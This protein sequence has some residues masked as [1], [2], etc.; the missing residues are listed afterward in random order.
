[1]NETRQS[2]VRERLIRLLKQ[3]FVYTIG[4]LA[5]PI[6]G[7][8]MVPIYTRVF[9]PEDYGIIDLIQITIV[10]ISV[11]LIMGTDNATGRFYLDK[12]NEKDKRTIAA[13]SLIFR[14]VVLA[15]ASILLVLFSENI[16]QMLFKSGRGTQFLVLAIIAIPFDHCFTLCLNMLRY[17]YRSISYTLLSVGKLIGKISLI[18]LFVVF[19]KWGIRGVFSAALISSVVFLIAVMIVTRKYFSFTFSV[20]RLKE[21]LRYGLP[22]VPYGFTVYL[23][24]NCARYFL[25]H[26]GTLEDVGLYAV[27]AKLATLISFVFIGIGAALDPYIFSSYKDEETRRLYL[28]TTNYLVGA[29]VV[30]VLGL[31]LFTREILLIF[32]T[33][34]YINAQAVVP[35][36][37]AYMAFFYLGFQMSQGIHIAQKTIYFT[38]ISIITAVVTIVLNLIL[39]PSYGMM[40][41]AIA[42]LGGSIVWCLLLLFQSQVY[43]RVEYKYGAFVVMFILAAAIIFVSH[44]FFAEI[45]LLNIVVK[46]GLIIITALFTYFTGLIGKGELEYIKSLPSKIIHRNK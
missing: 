45:S 9:A 21:L 41:A 5:S 43:Y 40:G 4:S 8:F 10:F 33:S 34:K 37:A 26:Y 24:Q 15:G 36:L 38:V 29:S 32:T 13:T 19:F 17:E 42:T 25:A 18:I 39:V 28:K 20:Y 44:K 14:V 23:I 1:M 3:S 30:A 16:S 27:A 31:S 2:T 46:T 6:A 7:I 35:F 11:A 22:L 12:D